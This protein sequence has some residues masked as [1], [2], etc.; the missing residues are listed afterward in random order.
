MVEHEVT[1]ETDIELPPSVTE[2]SALSLMNHILDA[3][4]IEESWSLGIQFVDDGTMQAAHAEF[5]DIDE[6]TDIMTFPYADDDD[7]WGGD[8]S[9]GDLIISVDRARSNATEAGWN[10]EDELFFL[11]AHGLLHLLG[12]NDLTDEDRLKM[13]ARQQELIDSWADRPLQ[14]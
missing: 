8:Q 4:G 2:L 1:F 12:W 11:I 7:V 14:A 13:L 10:E 6:P 5:M 9:G 3:E